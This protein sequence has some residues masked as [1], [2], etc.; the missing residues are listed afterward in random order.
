MNVYVTL[1]SCEIH[2]LIKIIVK[3]LSVISLPATIYML[4]SF[5]KEADQKLK[6][7]KEKQKEEENKEDEM[8]EASP[9]DYP[10]FNTDIDFK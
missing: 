5:K 1:L 8:L 10:A 2:P 3:L 6:E 7:Y 4:Y 9:N